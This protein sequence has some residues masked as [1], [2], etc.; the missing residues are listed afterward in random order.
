LKK[1]SKLTNKNSLLFTQVHKSKV[2]TG[3]NSITDICGGGYQCVM[4]HVW[5]TFC[6]TLIP[7]PGVSPTYM[8]RA[9]QLLIYGGTYLPLFPNR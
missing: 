8:W 5:T 9:K 4:A 6:D 7:K 2:S 1:D 3:Y